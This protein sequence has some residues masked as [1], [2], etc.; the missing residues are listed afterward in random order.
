MKIKALMSEKEL[1]AERLKDDINKLET[2]YS[3]R[4]LYE[5]V[6][7]V[8]LGNDVKISLWQNIVQML[9]FKIFKRE[10]PVSVIKEHSDLQEMLDRIRF[11]QSYLF[12][13]LHEFNVEPLSQ[14]EFSI[15]HDALPH[16][17][18]K[19]SSLPSVMSNEEFIE[20]AK[21]DMQKIISRENSGYEDHFKKIE[22]LLTGKKLALPSPDDDD[23]D[24]DDILERI[25]KI[26]ESLGM[27]KKEEHENILET[28]IEEEHEESDKEKK[29]EKEMKKVN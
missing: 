18:K 29:K 21:Q 9:K 28:N 14:K 7:H 5:K 19:L 6:F 25:R 20:N 17:Q 2:I 8:K 10:Y 23:D 22:E 16:L 26:R 11:L 13:N 27:K 24:D 15:Y 12:A 3:M 4:K 1:I